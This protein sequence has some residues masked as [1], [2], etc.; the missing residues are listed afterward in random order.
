[1]NN[2]QEFEIINK[3]F[4]K[5][6]WDLS[7]IECM[8]ILKLDDDEYVVLEVKF[9]II[10]IIKDDFKQREVVKMLKIRFLL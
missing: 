10:M 2:V 8:K 7:K 1:M 5:I 9:V 6:L 4:Y 3:Q